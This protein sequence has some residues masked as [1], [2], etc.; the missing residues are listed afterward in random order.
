MIRKS[1]NK[2]IEKIME[3][4]EE[5]TIKAHDFINKDYWKNN[6]NTVKNEYMP[7]SETFVYDD[8]EEIKGFISI[9][10]NE[11]IGALFISTNYQNLGIGS[12]LL[13]YALKEY[14]NL[15]LAVY[16]D[17]KK[18]VVFY[19][20][21]GFNIVKEQINEDSGFKEYIME[22]SKQL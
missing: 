19:I 15:S 22:Y 8:E 4:W 17:N 9:I 5:S 13:D 11:F 2:D 3:I 7:I 1:N 21:K 14:K 18:A 20:K 10:D 6:Y 16:K 12:K